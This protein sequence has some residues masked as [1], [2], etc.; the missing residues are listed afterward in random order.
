MLAFVS[1]QLSHIRNVRGSP[2]R[3]IVPKEFRQGHVLDHRVVQREN[4]VLSVDLLR[5]D[6]HAGDEKKF[7]QQVPK[8]VSAELVRFNFFTYADILLCG[9]IK[10]MISSQ[11]FFNNYDLHE[12]GYACTQYGSGRYNCGW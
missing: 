6:S 5:R 3:D 12:C 7:P 8:F 10:P 1:F 4:A 11:A 9:K 2:V